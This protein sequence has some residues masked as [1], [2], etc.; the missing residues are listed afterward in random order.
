MNEVINMCYIKLT[1][2][3]NVIVSNNTIDVWIYIF[4]LCN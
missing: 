3:Y 2:I 1:L 4:I